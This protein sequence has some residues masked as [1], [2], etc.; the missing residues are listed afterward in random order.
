MKELYV[1]GL[2]NHNGRESCAD[3]R[4]DDSEAL[5]AVHTGWVLS[6]E[7]AQ[8][9]GAD[10]LALSGRQNCGHREARCRQALRGRVTA[11]RFR[12]QARVETLCKG[13]G[14]VH[15]SPRKI[16]TWCA[17]GIPKGTSQ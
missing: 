14:R 3:V 6:P 7:N 4:K 15:G 10:V 1:E 9:Q 11:N 13:T 2:A 8:V 12:P 17:L 5:T 16:E